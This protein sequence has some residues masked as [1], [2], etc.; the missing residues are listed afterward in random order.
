MNKTE[1][2]EIIKTKHLK[3]RKWSLIEHYFL[4]ILFL[5]MPMVYLIVIVESII[6]NNT[7]VYDKA[8]SEIGF[9]LIS[10]FIAIIFLIIKRKAIKFK[11]I[12]LKVSKQDFD[13]AVELTQTELDW[14]ILEKNSKYVIAF[15]KN[16]FGGFSETIRIIKKHNLI[17][18]NSIGSPYSMPL[19]GRNEENIETFKQ[20]L[21]KANVQHRV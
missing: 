21:T 4:V 11:T 10:L 15:S 9:A 13:K 5:S 14:L 12:D 17:L 6:E 3:L 1:I 20:N 18:I 16:N 19:S 8:M 7:I 2:S